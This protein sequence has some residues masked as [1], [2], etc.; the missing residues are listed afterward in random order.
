MSLLP[1][2]F[3][4]LVEVPPSV[5]YFIFLGQFQVHSEIERKVQKFGGL[6][7]LNCPA[8]VLQGHYW[9]YKTGCP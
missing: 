8:L 2:L 1:F 7:P 6:I 3:N 9:S 4:I 5:P